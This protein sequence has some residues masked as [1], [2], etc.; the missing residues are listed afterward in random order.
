M[1]TKEMKTTVT[2]T[3]FLLLFLLYPSFSSPLL[4]R[5]ETSPVFGS[6]SPTSLPL[7]FGDFN[8]DKLTDLIV[9]DS[10]DRSKV[11]VLLAQEQTL[12]M[13]EEKYFLT[14]EQARAQSE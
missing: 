2:M 12:S 13:Q 8:S 4:L 14:A 5:N 7:A 9:L 6:P 11:S 1:L 10:L 3:M